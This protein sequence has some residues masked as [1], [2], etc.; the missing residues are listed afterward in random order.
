MNPLKPSTAMQR[1]IVGTLAISV[2]VG[3]VQAIAWGFGQQAQGQ[4]LDRHYAAHRAD[5]TVA[6]QARNSQPSV[7]MA[8][9]AAAAT[10]SLTDGRS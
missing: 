10:R 9:E 2:T 7:P 1:L 5:E 8:L 4:S 6:D 3:V